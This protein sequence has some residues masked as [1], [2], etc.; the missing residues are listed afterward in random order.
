MGVDYP[1]FRP[2]TT[3]LRAIAVSRIRVSWF[4]SCRARA[5]VSRRVPNVSE[6]EPG[7]WR[8][9]DECPPAP[10][11]RGKVLGKSGAALGGVLLRAESIGGP[12][13]RTRL[14]DPNPGANSRSN[15]SCSRL[16]SVLGLEAGR[17]HADEREVEAA[18]AVAGHEVAVRIEGCR[19]S[20]R[21]AGCSG[22]SHRRGRC[23]REAVKTWANCARTARRPRGLPAASRDCDRRVD[24]AADRRAAPDGTPR[25]PTA[26]TSRSTR[27]RG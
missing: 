14:A 7:A 27:P 16:H 20:W 25:R 19:R 12:R 5:R 18:L 13:E 24:A 1:R 21:L 22:W 4:S 23:R 3:G 6:R 8:R 15:A 17:L 10:S 9:G 26:R 11:I 2:I